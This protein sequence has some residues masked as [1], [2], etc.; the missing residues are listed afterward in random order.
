MGT[1]EYMSPEQ[2]RG[3][4]GTFGPPTDVYGMGAVLYELLAGR[5][6]FPGLTLTETLMAIERTDPN[7]LICFGKA[8][9]PTWKP[10]A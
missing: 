3:D 10:F 4:R 6:P 1:P 9:R 5:S 8:C 2:A 7:R